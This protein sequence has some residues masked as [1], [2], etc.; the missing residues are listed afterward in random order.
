LKIICKRKISI[1]AKKTNII[2]D[3][4]KQLNYYTSK[5]E[6]FDLQVSEY[7]NEIVKAEEKHCE[8]IK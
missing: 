2:L 8:S 5:I 1:V 6:E 7:S 4:Q 3:L